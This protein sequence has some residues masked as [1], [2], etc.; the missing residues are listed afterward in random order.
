V[1]QLIAG[2]KDIAW[3]YFAMQQ[4]RHA[5]LQ[6]RLLVFDFRDSFR[7]LNAALGFQISMLYALASV[8]SLSTGSVFQMA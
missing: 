2:Q 1:Y 6:H 8:L 7:T 4:V 5:L 3:R